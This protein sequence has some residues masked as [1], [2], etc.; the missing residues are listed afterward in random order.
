MNINNILTDFAKISLGIKAINEK[1]DGNN[2]VARL[3]ICYTDNDKNKNL[4]VYNKIIEYTKELD[5][6]NFSYKVKDNKYIYLLN[7]T[8]FKDVNDFTKIQNMFKSKDKILT[9]NIKNF[10]NCLD[11]LNL[12][13]AILKDNRQQPTTTK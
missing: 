5:K 3:V 1:L 6:L 8:E 9:I 12:A 13:L 10:V 11:F 4:D 7:K 2:F